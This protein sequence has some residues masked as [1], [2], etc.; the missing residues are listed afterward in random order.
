MGGNVIRSKNINCDGIFG[1]IVLNI[2]AVEGI[3]AA[4]SIAKLNDSRLWLHS[5]SVRPINSRLKSNIAS[6]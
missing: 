2:D 3:E 4:N 1:D 5:K 6:L